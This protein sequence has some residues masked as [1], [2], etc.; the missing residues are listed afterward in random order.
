VAKTLGRL[1]TLLS[2]LLQDLPGTSDG[3]SGADPI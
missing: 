1:H 3:R 2:V